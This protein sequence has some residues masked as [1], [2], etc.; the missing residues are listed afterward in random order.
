MRYLGITFVIATLGLAGHPAV[1]GDW[2]DLGAVRDDTLFVER[3]RLI[4]AALARNEML[5]AS[6]AMADA[7]SA[8]AT[9]AWAG[10]L[11][12]VAVGEFFLRSDDAL[13]AFG[14]KLVNRGAQPADFAPDVLNDPGEVNNWVTQIK[15][16]QPV[17]NAGMSL[18]GKQAADAAGLA[19]QFQHRRAAETVRLQAVQIHEGL[20]L[21]HA[22]IDVVEGAIRGAEAHEQRAQA[23][24]AAEMAT[25][26]DL[27]QARVFLAT[28]RQQ[29][30]SV[31][32]QAA[33]AADAVQLL[34][35]T[36]IPLALAAAAA[37]PARDLP[38]VPDPATVTARRSDL[39]A[40]EQQ[41]RAA[42]KMVG[43][44]TGAML[45]HLNVSL[46][47][48]YYSHDTV[49]GGDAASWSL[50]AYATWNVF[51]GL[52]SVAARRQARAEQRA[53]EYGW[54]FQTRQA[55]QEAQQA[56]RDVAAAAQRLTV[57]R[58]AVGAARESLRIVGDQYGEGLASMTDLLDVQA[59]EIAAAGGLAQANHDYNVS[60]A[61]L[62]YA[63]GNPP[64]EGGAQ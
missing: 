17:F 12:H 43:V 30:I 46:E 32:N 15:L 24:V 11:P 45:P 1:A 22:M 18:Y 23:L 10:F 55:R 8:R 56:W 20:R 5:A 35:A 31:R 34:T 60:L 16:Q 52:Q 36:E 40:A 64:N 13:N 41:A 9:G 6:G 58:E 54:N 37:P 28:L 49:F 50:G 21:S 53:A 38:A 39:L 48:D 44:A 57:A 14:Y 26:A 59:A 3:D 42:G 47:R 33:A 63:A 7:A 2:Q 51:D 62:D 61:R 4:A 29:L 25:E 19:A 27:L